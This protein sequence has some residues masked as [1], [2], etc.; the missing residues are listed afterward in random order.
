[1]SQCS[2]EL[3]DL[4]SAAQY[5]ERALVALAAQGGSPGAVP[6]HA[7]LEPWNQ[8]RRAQACPSHSAR[9]HPLPGGTQ[10]YEATRLAH[11][12]ATL[13]QERKALEV[14]HRFSAP[15]GGADAGVL[16]RGQLLERAGLLEAQGVLDQLRKAL[17]QLKRR[18]KRR[19]ASRRP[20][21]ATRAALPPA[22]EVADMSV[23]AAALAAA[24]AAALAAATTSHLP[25]FPDASA[26]LAPG[27]IMPVLSPV[28]AA[29][30]AASA[31]KP[32][33]GRRGRAAGAASGAKSGAAAAARALP[34]SAE[35]QRLS[36]IAHAVMSLAPQPQHATVRSLRLRSGAM[37]CAHHPH[38]C[39]WIFHWSC[40]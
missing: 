15:N 1:M 20:D 29:P 24:Q 32:R 21:A 40:C 9:P 18:R 37:L 35:R 30:I 8:V 17:V 36:A 39:S 31:A 33:A 6:R 27:A 28:P 4:A 7:R 11:L 2:E 38:S 19:P 25:M 26:A 12:L 34:T 13:G 22:P 16:S 10:E 5:A 3:Q 23:S 14:L